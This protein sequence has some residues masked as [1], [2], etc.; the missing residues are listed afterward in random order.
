MDPARL[1]RI[2]SDLWRKSPSR[3]G[4][5]VIYCR[6][7]G[8]WTIQAAANQIFNISSAAK[9]ILLAAVL[10]L[11]EDGHLGWQDALEIRRRDRIATSRMTDGLPDGSTLPVET[12]CAAM[13]EDN[14]NTATEVLLRA[15]GQSAVQ[16]LLNAA[17]LRQTRL[18]FSLRWL[19]AHLYG[20]E[21]DLGEDESLADRT[22][23]LAP[24]LDR[25]GDVFRGIRST[26]GELNT[27]YRFILEGEWFQKKSTLEAFQRIM[28]L[29]DAAQKI[30][31]P[32]GWVCYRKGSQ[33]DLPPFYSAAQ[34]GCVLSAGERY[35]FTFCFNAQSVPLEQLEA[36]LDT[37]RNTILTAFTAFREGAIG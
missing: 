15:A 36:E 7:D 20:V 33:L 14:D 8:G 11:V 27:F 35:Y 23:G 3:F 4:Y 24:I 12:L 34:A 10:K 32:P 21:T 25:V 5:Q 29:E 31:W 28:K 16:R 18:P 22:S 2:I 9:P 1:K 30:I 19:I 26:P 17:G 6:P 13:I 37:F